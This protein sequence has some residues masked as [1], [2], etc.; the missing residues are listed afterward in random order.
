VLV[1]GCRPIRAKKAHFYEDGELKARILSP[2]LLTA[3]TMLIGPDAAAAPQTGDWADAVVAAPTV[4]STKDPAN[5]GIRREPELPEHE[6]IVPQP[7]QPV[8]EFEPM[9]EDADNEP[10]RPWM[11]QRTM[12]TVARQISLDSGDDMQM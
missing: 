2:P 10:Q 3:P 11:M 1:S 12:S 6:E 7:R 8:H 9:D 4:G 5:A